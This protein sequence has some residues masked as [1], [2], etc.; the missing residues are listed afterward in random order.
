MFI[1]D[2][3][4]LFVSDIEAEQN[5]Y[6][7]ALDFIKV[8]EC[9]PNEKVRMIF[10]TDKSGFYK[11]QLINGKGG[12]HPDFGHLAVWSDD[13]D[14]AFE[15]HRTMNCTTTDI[16]THK[17]QQSYFISDPDGYLTEVINKN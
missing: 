6:E 1:A 3:T 2:H 5:F 16:I 8:D 17:E 10:M 7:K 11:L 14:K 12:P 15:M 13:F 9:R 4:C